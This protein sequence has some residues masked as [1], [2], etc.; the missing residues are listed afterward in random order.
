MAAVRLSISSAIE[1]FSSSGT[2]EPSHMCDWK[3]GL[4]PA[5]TSSSEAA[6]S[7]RTKPSRASLGQW[8]VW[9]ATVMG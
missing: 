2:A 4:R 6:I 1:M 7:G 5:L 3:S 8:S 9:S